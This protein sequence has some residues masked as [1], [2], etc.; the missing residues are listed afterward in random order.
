[1]KNMFVVISLV[2]SLF[3]LILAGTF[4][5]SA[6][7]DAITIGSAEEFVQLMDGTYA[8]D[9]TTSTATITK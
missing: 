1:M 4:S 8:W 2:V 6:A 9:G 3:A 7:D 5:A